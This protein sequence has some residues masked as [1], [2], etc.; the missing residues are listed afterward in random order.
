MAAIVAAVIA[1]TG[2]G[3]WEERRYGQRAGEAAHA[4]GLDLR[5]SAGAAVAWSTAIAVVAIIPVSLVGG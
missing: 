1:A 2:V 4:Y 5:I 3:I